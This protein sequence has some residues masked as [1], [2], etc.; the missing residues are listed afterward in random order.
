MPNP[1]ALQHGV[2]YHIFNRGNNRENILIEERNYCR[3]LQPYARYVEPVTDTYAYCL[4]CNH[5]HLRVRI[6]T[7]EKQSSLG[8]WH[9]ADAEAVGR[10]LQAVR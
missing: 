4:L 1:I 2:Y 9:V 7:D 5:F 8:G 3:F 6:K 10:I